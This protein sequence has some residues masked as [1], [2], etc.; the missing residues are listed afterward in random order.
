MLRRAVLT[1]ATAAVDS[2]ARR[3]LGQGLAGATNRVF[4]DA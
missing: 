2:L 4:S 1:L 3:Q